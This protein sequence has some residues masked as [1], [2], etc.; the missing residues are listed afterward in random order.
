[1]LAREV[2]AALGDEWSSEAGDYEDRDA[3]LIGPEGA[4]ILKCLAPQRAGAHRPARHHTAR[5]ARARADTGSHHRD[6]RVADQER[7]PD[8]QGCAAP[9]FAQL[10]GIPGGGTGEQEPPRGP[11]RAALAAELA[12]R[13][14]PE[15][16]VRGIDGNLRVADYTD[17]GTVTVPFSDDEV[18]FDL[19]FPQ[20]L[21]LD[22]ATA[23]GELRAKASEQ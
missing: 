15:V 22:L 10:P 7:D 16:T 8:R 11:G 23:I 17:G 3:F 19:P 1:M 14:G 5:T 12:T 20:P 9:A 6:Q 2:A 13:L 21:A 4:R 18:P